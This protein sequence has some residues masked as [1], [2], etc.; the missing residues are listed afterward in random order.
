M[1]QNQNHLKKENQNQN[2][3]KKDKKKEKK[4][5]VS[6]V[7]PLIGDNSLTPYHI[8]DHLRGLCVDGPGARNFWDDLRR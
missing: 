4:V 6:G 2:H 7:T 8:P 5:G 1:D 3:L